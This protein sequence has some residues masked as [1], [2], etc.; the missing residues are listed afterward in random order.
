MYWNLQI[1]KRNN[2]E[3]LAIGWVAPDDMLFRDYF[4]LSMKWCKP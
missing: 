4:W 3:K 2:I 1:S